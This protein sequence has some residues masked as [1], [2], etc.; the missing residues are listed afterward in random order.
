MKRLLLVFGAIFAAILMTSSA[1][2]IPQ[3]YGSTTMDMVNTVEQKIITIEEKLGVSK[4]N[5]LQL[6]LIPE[7]GG[8]IDLIIRL[9]ELLINIVEAVIQFIL[10]LFNIVELIQTLLE[11]IQILVQLIIDFINWIIGL[12]N[13]EI[14]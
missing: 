14:I 7:K 10:D 4:E 8:L 9:I 6:N 5:L 11:K 12:F 1:T 3:V 2:A 13:P